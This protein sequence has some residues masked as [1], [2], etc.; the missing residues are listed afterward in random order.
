MIT[1]EFAVI[2]TAE[3]D[4][5]PHLMRLYSPDYPRSFL[6]DGRRELQTPNADDLRQLLGRKE[7]RSGVFHVVEDLEGTVRGCC[8]LKYPAHDVFYSEILLAFEDLAD[9]SQPIARE[10]MEFIEY[11]AFVERRLNKIV[12][13]CIENEREYRDLLLRERFEPN[14]LQRD[15]LFTMGRY[16]DLETLS[17]FRHTYL[18]RATQAPA[19]RGAEDD[20]A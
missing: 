12:A 11:T 19:Q 5:A 13:Q 9:Y 1:G 7:V 10:T 3:P 6:L 8:S 14:G 16:H 18:E 15:V 17:L 4:D 2:R 20:S